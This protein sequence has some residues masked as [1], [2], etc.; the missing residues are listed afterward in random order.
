MIKGVR[1]RV[2][3]F[4]VEWIPDPLAG[5]LLH[6]IPD[7]VRDP[8]EIMHRMW[9]QGGAT[10]DDPRPFLKTVVCRIVSIAVLERR[11]QRDSEVTLSLR[12][13][14]R[15]TESAAEIRES[16]VI[17]TFLQALGER[18]PQLVGFNSIPSDLKILVQRG[19]ILGIRA[20][21]FC[22]RPNKP[23]EGIDYFAR[24]SEWNIDLKD[25]VGGWGKVVPSLHEIA[26]QSG[27]PGKMDVDGSQVADLWLN[28]EL[29]RIVNY[30]EFDAITTYLV[31]LR[32]AHFA[33]HFSTPEYGEEQRR[34]Q[35]LLEQ[36]SKSP[37]GAHL[38]TY[39][40]EWERLS[41]IVE[42]SR[43]G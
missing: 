32:L 27:I 13:L 28:G 7:S 29:R 43:D 42:L 11:V 17:E 35:D 15:N 14:P 22:R 10:E 4:D 16:H 1:D 37:E 36:K 9:A 34:V 24:G 5:Q 33:G 6:E 12:S 21:D 39:L 2:W 30:N 8:K 41:R 19:L 20:E 26:V 18:Q 23:W 40:D 25:V 3:A 31:W 38:Q